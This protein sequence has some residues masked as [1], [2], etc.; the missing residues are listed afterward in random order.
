MGLFIM[1]FKGCFGEGDVGNNQIYNGLDFPNCGKFAFKFNSDITH[2][3]KLPK[4]WS[5]HNFLKLAWSE[6]I[7]FVCS[8]IVV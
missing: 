3:N 4:E 5:N 2:I 8:L 6:D 1:L 7:L